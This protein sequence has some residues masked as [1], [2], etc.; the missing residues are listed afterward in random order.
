VATKQEGIQTNKEVLES[1][2]DANFSGNWKPNHQ[3]TSID[4]VQEIDAAR[5]WMKKRFS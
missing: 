3:T 1:W 4:G 2:C 5:H